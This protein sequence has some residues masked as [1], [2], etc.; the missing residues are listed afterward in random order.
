MKYRALRV[1]AV[2]YKILAWITLVIGVIISISLLFSSSIV[3]RGLGV[4]VSFGASFI[5]A[6]L[7]LGFTLLQ[8][9]F[10]LGFGELISLLFDIDANTAPKLKKAPATE[11]KQAA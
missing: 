2:V 11:T 10:F 6:L 3:S 9:V 7:T 8:F 5:A 4:S 1:L